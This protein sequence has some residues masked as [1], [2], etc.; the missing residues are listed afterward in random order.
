M[1][2]SMKPP[3]PAQSEVGENSQRP[4]GIPQ[5]AAG[6]HQASPMTEASDWRAHGERRAT[7]SG[8]SSG[9][10]RPKNGQASP[11]RQRRPDPADA[12][13][14]T[15]GGFFHSQV[16]GLTDSQSEPKS[17]RSSLRPTLNGDHVNSSTNSEL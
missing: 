13:L 8:N 17:R 6:Q 7:T 9:V 1:K 4:S 14:R 16:L 11:Q 12:S 5:Q 10:E 3:W 15:T 2:Q